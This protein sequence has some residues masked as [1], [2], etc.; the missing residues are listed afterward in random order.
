M[1]CHAKRVR[2]IH[3]DKIFK[4]TPW[5]SHPTCLKLTLK[6][7]KSNFMCPAEGKFVPDLP[8]HRAPSTSALLVS[9]LSFGLDKHCQL[10][11]IN[12]Q[13]PQALLEVSWIPS[14]ACNNNQ[15]RSPAS[16]TQ[17]FR[18][19][20]SARAALCPAKVHESREKKSTTSQKT[21]QQPKQ[22]KALWNCNL[23]ISVRKWKEEACS[24][25][26]VYPL[27]VSQQWH[28]AIL[29]HR[30]SFGDTKYRR[31]QHLWKGTEAKSPT[32]WVRHLLPMPCPATSQELQRPR[33]LQGREFKGQNAVYPCCYTFAANKCFSSPAPNAAKT[34]MQQY[35]VCVFGGSTGEFLRNHSRV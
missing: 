2:K 3:R 34:L 14:D 10:H 31:A 33:P 17:D 25:G 19:W 15:L 5:Q 22:T 6:L 9:A 32:Q 23:W 18:D 1:Y 16:V 26:S 20:F 11:F 30:H 24:K 4:T 13:Q 12:G 27:L 28:W 21:K 29:E 35:S 8:P 7:E